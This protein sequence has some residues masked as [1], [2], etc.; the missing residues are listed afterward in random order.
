MEYED[1]YVIAT[2]E[3]VELAVPL[4]G[5]GSRFMAAMIDIVIQSALIVVTVTIAA[6]ALG[7]VGAAVALGASQLAFILGYNVL[8]EVLGGG[9]TLGKR[10]S[11]LRVVRTGGAP[12][13]LRASLIRNIIRLFELALLYVPSIVSILATRDNQRLGDLAAGTLVV[14]DARPA[15]P[16]APPARAIDPAAYASWDVTGVGDQ[17]TIAVRAFLQRRAELHPTAR[18][19]IAAELA[20]KLRPL[21]AGARAGLDDDTFLELLS[22]AKAKYRR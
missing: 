10:A 18:H 19:A 16:L 9:R 1:R 11:S 22:A 4:A 14:R 2:P 21:V 17:E 6:I 15:P 7:G 3:G 13:D 20:G 12:V 5:L 8:C